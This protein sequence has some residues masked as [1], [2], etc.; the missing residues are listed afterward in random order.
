MATTSYIHIR[1]I[2]GTSMSDWLV[3]FNS[4]CT[5]TSIYE[6]WPMCS[7]N[8]AD[9]LRQV[10]LAPPTFVHHIAHTTVHTLH[11]LKLRLTLK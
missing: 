2:T 7:N 10:H 8:I 1:Y 9:G 3:H 5:T 4:K 11:N 6:R